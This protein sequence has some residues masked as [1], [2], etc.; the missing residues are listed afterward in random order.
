[1]IDGELPCIIRGIY[2]HP[3][4]AKW[5][6][7]QPEKDLGRLGFLI[8]QAVHA[9][10]IM[11]NNL[12]WLSDATPEPDLPELIWFPQHASRATYIELARREPRM[13]CS[14]ARACMHANYE[15]AFDKVAWEP[16]YRI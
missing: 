3:F 5:W 8:R 11:N 12:S 6:L 10:C 15:E 13:A 9:R 1:M 14:A 4:F 16:S 7:T 2:H